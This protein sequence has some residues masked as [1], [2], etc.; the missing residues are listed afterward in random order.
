MKKFHEKLHK[1]LLT[2][3][4]KLVNIHC[5]RNGLTPFNPEKVK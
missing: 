5:I 4:I 3:K 2:T 1:K